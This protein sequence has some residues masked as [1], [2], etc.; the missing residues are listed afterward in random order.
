MNYKNIFLSRVSVWKSKVK[1]REG[2]RIR[3]S[4]SLGYAVWA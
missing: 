3:M 4:Y 2:K 1:E